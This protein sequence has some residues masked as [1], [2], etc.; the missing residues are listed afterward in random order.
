MISSSRKITHKFRSFLNFHSSRFISISPK[1]NKKIH[2]SDNPVSNLS[3]FEGSFQVK[4]PV[5]RIFTT[6]ASGCLEVDTET[7]QTVSPFPDQRLSGLFSF[8]QHWAVAH[9]GFFRRL[10]VFGGELVKLLEM[11]DEKMSGR[12]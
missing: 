3:T 9:W 4:Q 8:S 12:M 10:V 5:D 6:L 1:K 7:P 11:F 2:H